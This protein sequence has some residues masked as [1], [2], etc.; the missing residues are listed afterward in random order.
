MPFVCV[1]YSSNEAGTSSS[2]TREVLWLSISRFPYQLLNALVNKGDTSVFSARSFYKTVTHLELLLDVF[3]QD[4]VKINARVLHIGLNA[5]MESPSCWLYDDLSG[6]MWF[7][8][9]E[10]DVPTQLMIPLVI[11]FYLSL[12]LNELVEVTDILL[13]PAMCWPGHTAPL[14][15]ELMTS[16]FPLTIEP[17]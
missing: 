7:D 6:I 11:D 15:I 8:G 4:S 13:S 16:S 17:L 9:I 14:F 2:Y 1:L 12:F 3:V 5:W 10:V